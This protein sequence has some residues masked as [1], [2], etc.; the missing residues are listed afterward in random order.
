M[1]VDRQRRAFALGVLAASALALGG[2][3]T[4]VADLQQAAPSAGTAAG[5]PADVSFQPSQVGTYLP[6]EDSPPEPDDEVITPEQRAKIEAELIAARNRQAAAVQNAQ[7][8]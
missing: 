3:S 8:K 5:T 4:Q 6:V 7:A 1:S 2:C